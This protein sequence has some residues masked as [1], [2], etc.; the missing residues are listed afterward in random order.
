MM[1]TPLLLPVLLV[2]LLTATLQ[3]YTPELQLCSSTQFLN[4]Q[5]KK[6]GPIITKK[7]D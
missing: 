1:K 2:T 4:R 5:L 7:I 3:T 6:Y